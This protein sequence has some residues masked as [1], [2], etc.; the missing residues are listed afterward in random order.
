MKVNTCEAIAKYIERCDERLSVFRGICVS[1]IGFRREGGHV[2]Q[3]LPSG[4]LKK[5][6]QGRCHS[7][8]F[9]F[10][11]LIGPPVLLPRLTLPAA[12]EFTQVDI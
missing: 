7:R 11:Q 4:T 12:K 8:R 9:V 3:P 1:S 5:S 6:G 10:Q 2:L